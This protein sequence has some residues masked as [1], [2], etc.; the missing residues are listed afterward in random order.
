MSSGPVVFIHGMYMNGRSWQPWVERASAAGHACHAPSWP[1]HDGS[2]AAL[3]ANIDPELGKL[4]FGEVTDQLKAFIDTLPQRPA[5]VGH[6]IGALAVQK[7]VND[8][9]ATAGVCL[10]PAPPRGVLS[11]DPHFVRANFPHANPLAGNAPVQMTPQRFHYAFANTVTEA[12]SAALFEEYVVP[13][14]RN[15]PRSTLT[16]QGQIDFRRAHA[17]MLFIA[18]SDDH[19][20]PA[21]MVRRNVRAYRKSDGVIDFHQF[22]GRSHIICSEPGWQDVADLALD[23]LARHR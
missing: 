23:W 11:G 9:Y 4:T 7:L 17:P 16:R 2:P 22:Q 12:A 19:L 6:S 20:T 5:L 15:V 21:A 18:A 3:R 1:F 14:S 13:E 10:T 8:G